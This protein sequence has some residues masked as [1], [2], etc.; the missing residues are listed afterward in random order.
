MAIIK[1]PECGKELSDK[2][3]VCP[4]CG[5]PIQEINQGTENT[6][7]K[8]LYCPNCGGTNIS[9]QSVQEN[10][11]SETRATTTTKYKEK[12]HGCL[13]WLIIGWWWWMVDLF[14]WIFAFLPRLILR[15]FAAP[16]KKK[17]GVSVGQTVAH[18]T[19][20]IVYR[21]VCTCQTCG[22]VW[23]KD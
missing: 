2:A 17:K 9:I 16:F 3:S 21:T 18:T 1:C 5:F 14:L 23:R 20:K 15:L 6:N 22:N 19:N 13:W 7:S 11:G 10:I 8:Q 4:Q 12:G